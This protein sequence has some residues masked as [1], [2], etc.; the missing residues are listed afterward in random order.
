MKKL[1]EKI[2][3]FGVEKFCLNILV[4]HGISSDTLLF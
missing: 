2:T 1:S 4:G 3:Y